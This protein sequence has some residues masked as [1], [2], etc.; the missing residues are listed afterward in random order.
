MWQEALQ[1]GMRCDAGAG[2]GGGGEGGKVGG[3]LLAFRFVPL[4][5]CCGRC[6]RAL[7]QGQETDSRSL[8]GTHVAATNQVNLAL[9]TLHLWMWDASSRHLQRALQ[10]DRSLHAAAGWD[11][12]AQQPVFGGYHCVVFG[13]MTWSERLLCLRAVAQHVTR[14]I[15]RPFIALVHSPPLQLLR[16]AYMSSDF[17]AHTTGA[18]ILGLFRR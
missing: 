18:N 6:E 7:L 5:P 11:S 17:A 13:S 12:G 15:T 2:L 16:V 14:H 1:A 10:L 4:S 9:Y 8:S 3:G